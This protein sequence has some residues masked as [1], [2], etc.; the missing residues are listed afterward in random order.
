M[1]QSVQEPEN[2]EVDYS[3][4]FSVRQGQE[5]Q[6]E[7]VLRNTG[8][9]AIHVDEIDL[10]EAFGGSILDGAVTVA[11]Q[12]EMTRDFS[13]PGIKTFIYNRR[14]PSEEATTVVFNLKAVEAGEFGGSVGVWVGDRVKRLHYVSVTV[15]ED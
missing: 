14:L 12:P 9:T 3:I 15:L 5:F 2:L 8:D 11:T 7:L 13:I 4:P 10:D 1:A 6:F